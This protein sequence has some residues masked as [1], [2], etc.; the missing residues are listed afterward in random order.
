MPLKRVTLT[1]QGSV[2]VLDLHL[3]EPLGQSMTEGSRARYAIAGPDAL[4]RAEMVTWDRSFA[5]QD[6]GRGRW[7]LFTPASEAGGVAQYEAAALFGHEAGA[8]EEAEI[9]VDALPCDADH[10]CQLLLR[11]DHIQ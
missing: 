4:C 5:S 11:Q 6:D 8:P 1:K 3:S 10:V 2:R 7:R 9:S